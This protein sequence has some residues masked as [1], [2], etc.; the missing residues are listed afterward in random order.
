ML[1]YARVFLSSFCCSLSLRISAK[2][3]L[4]PQLV[5]FLF[6]N[7]F[8]SESFAIWDEPC[9]VL[10]FSS[11]AEVEEVE[12]SEKRSAGSVVAVLAADLA[13]FA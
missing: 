1:P 4:P 9:D 2:D 13:S 5:I 6:T 11:A 12:E 8:F 10:D 3:F 7:V